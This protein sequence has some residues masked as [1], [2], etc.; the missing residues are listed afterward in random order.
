MIIDEYRRMELSEAP[1]AQINA[2][3]VWHKESRSWRWVGKD[4]RLRPQHYD[5]TKNRAARDVRT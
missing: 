4:G 5:C 1:M 3:L 2:P